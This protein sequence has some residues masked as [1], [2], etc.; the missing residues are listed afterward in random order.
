[1]TLTLSEE[2]YGFNFSISI[3]HADFQAVHGQTLIEGLGSDV[4]GKRRPELSLLSPSYS[5]ATPRSSVTFACTTLLKIFIFPEDDILGD[6]NS[7]G[8]S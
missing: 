5:L 4:G 8:L 7:A 3:N 2:F 1:M 6:D